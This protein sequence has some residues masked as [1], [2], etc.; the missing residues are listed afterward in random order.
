MFA[1]LQNAILLI[2]KYYSF[3]SFRLY[4][5]AG[6]RVTFCCPGEEV[7]QPL[8]AQLK[9]FTASDW[10]SVPHC[11]KL[12]QSQW[13]TLS[14]YPTVKGVKLCWQSQQPTLSRYPAVKGVKLCWQSQRPT[15]SR[16]PAVKGVKLC[17]QSQRPTLSRYPTV[18]GVQLQYCA[19]KKKLETV[20][21]L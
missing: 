7:W 6:K 10:D 5:A 13:P 9:E 19:T 18:T 21:V 2:F 1:V 14:R 17:S 8:L 20:V 4:L 11:V 3:L 15:L 16:Y 12:W